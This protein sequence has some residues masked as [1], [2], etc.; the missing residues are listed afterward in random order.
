MTRLQ[1]ANRVDDIAPPNASALL[2]ATRSFLPFAKPCVGED[3]IQAVTETMRSGWLTTGPVTKLFEQEFAEAIGARHAIAVNSA[4]AGLHLA[5]EAIGVGPGDKVFTT[6]FT[7]TATAEVIRYMGADPIFVD[8]DPLTFN[9][10][11]NKLAAAAA[12]HPEAKAIMPVHFG[13]Q[14]C[15]MDAIADIAKHYGLIIVED[16][17]HAFPATSSGRMIGTIGDITV[18][19]FYANKT[20]TTGEGGM[21]VTA[22]PQLASRIQTM[23]LHGINRDAFDRFTSPTASWYYEV[24]AP[25]FKYNL[26]D[27]ASAIGRSQLTKAM[28]FRQQRAGIA[29]AYAE[30]LRGLPIELPKERHAND[31]H[32]WHLYVVKLSLDK[33]SISRDRFIEL[34]RQ[35]GIGTSVHYIPLHLQP[36]WRDRYSLTPAHFPEAD[37][38]YHRCVSLPIWHGMSTAE[39]Q[40]VVATVR[41]ILDA[42]A[43]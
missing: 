41:E 19:S 21:V 18:F 17:A 32:A 15:D 1:D 27:I 39:V 24:V 22:S 40:R 29:A 25:G 35:A 34:M 13:G 12:A 42:H 43:I 26:T 4:T 20:M 28:H 7:F 3:E 31:L 5:L 9:I 37:A 8:I 33:L 36:Y 10:D 6:P 30:G 38:A 16:A 23:R 14:A 11:V 2:A